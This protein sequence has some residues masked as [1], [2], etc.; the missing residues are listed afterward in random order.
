MDV[1]LAAGVREAGA[2]INKLGSH[3]API[4]TFRFATPAPCG[5]FADWRRMVGGDIG[6]RGRTRNAP[7]AS[8]GAAPRLPG[9]PC[10]CPTYGQ[11]YTSFVS[12]RP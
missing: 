7:P 8:G 10:G 5:G 9:L 12:T 11:T 1:S 4:A 3:G 2:P 6:G